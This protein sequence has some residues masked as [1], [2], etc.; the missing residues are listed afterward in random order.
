MFNYNFATE[1]SEEQKCECETLLLTVEALKAQLEEQTRLC[2]EQ[3][4][5]IQTLLQSYMYD[6]LSNYILN[7]LCIV[8]S[9]L[10]TQYQGF[11][12]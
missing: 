7:M 10:H 5:Y 1:N 12:W 11:I 2:K 8:I 9:E 6:N 3:V 4:N